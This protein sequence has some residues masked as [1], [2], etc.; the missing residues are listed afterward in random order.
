MLVDSSS[1]WTAYALSFINSLPFRWRLF[2]LLVLEYVKGQ[3][4][5]MQH[6]L[7]AYLLVGQSNLKMISMIV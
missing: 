6:D 1:V 5:I 4:G 3:T 7:C 2:G